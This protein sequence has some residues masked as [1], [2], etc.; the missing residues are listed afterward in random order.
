MAPCLYLA[1]GM[2]ISGMLS[3][4]VF[5]SQPVCYRLTRLIS[6]TKTETG[7]HEPLYMQGKLMGSWKERKNCFKVIYKKG[8]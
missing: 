7:V 1:A 2:T 6:E 5:K 4:V 3:L 8:A